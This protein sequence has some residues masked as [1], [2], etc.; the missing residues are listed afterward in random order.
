[1]SMVIWQDKTRQ[2][3]GECGC[4][5][6]RLY[7]FSSYFYKPN[8]IMMHV[9]VVFDALST[10]AHI[11]SKGYSLSLSISRSVYFERNEQQQTFF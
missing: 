6:Q 7:K 3:V 8:N 5:T 1:M 2:D 10:A 4:G 9:V 11:L